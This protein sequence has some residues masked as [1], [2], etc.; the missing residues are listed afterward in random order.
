M[1]SRIQEIVNDLKNLNLKKISIGSLRDKYQSGNKT[2]C[3]IREVIDYIILNNLKDSF[4]DKEF[5][6][7]FRDKQLTFLLECDNSYEVFCSERGGKHL[8]EKYD[9]Y[10]SALFEYLDRMFNE[11]SINAIDSKNFS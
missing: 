1:S 4:V 3:K 10:E 11:L 9:D 2:S 6:G 5:Y 8:L 7:D